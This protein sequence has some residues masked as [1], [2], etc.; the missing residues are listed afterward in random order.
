MSDA[1]IGFTFGFF[2][3]GLFGVAMICVLIAGRDED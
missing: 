1:M 2:F 3:G